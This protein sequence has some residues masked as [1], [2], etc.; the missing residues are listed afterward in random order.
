VALGLHLCVLATI[1]AGDRPKAD[2]AEEL[3]APAT[4]VYFAV[5]PTDSQTVRAVSHEFASTEQ[6][7]GGDG[8]AGESSA[9]VAPP[10]A[11]LMV[12]PRVTPRTVV[13]APAP[14]RR[15][16]RGGVPEG[17]AGGSRGGS[18]GGAGGSMAGPPAGVGETSEPVALRR[19]LPKY[20]LLARQARIEGEVVLDA[21]ILS[22]GT[23]GEVR[24]VRGLP[25]GCTQAAIE[26]LRRWS[27]RPGERDGV[28]VDAR[29]TLT[30]DFRI[31]D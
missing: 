22:D 13:T 8:A 20:P 25:L 10:A 3:P 16:A 9:E 24:V 4:Y 6:G 1:V 17:V 28:A 27:F 26:A 21:L 11:P 15:G 2:P 18:S 30:V 31:S 5:R 19:V 14:T 23:V 29:F 12:Q 7:P